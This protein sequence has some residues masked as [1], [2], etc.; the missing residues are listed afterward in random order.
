MAT[1]TSTAMNQH[2]RA[3]PAMYVGLA[4]TVAT[5]IA[6]YVDRA[7][8][9]VLASHIAA[10][11]PAYSQ[12]RLDSAVTIWLVVFSVVGA[13]GVAGW[14]GTIWAVESGKGW[15]RWTA[16]TLFALGISIA[17]T[18]VLITEPTGQQGLPL[19]LAWIGVLPSLAGAVA[20]AKLWRSS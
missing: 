9:G 12:A 5:T 17:L 7:T 15:A 8:T 18:L 3:V 14:I 20:V 6:P 11:W 4:L 2:R 16:T 19:V 13:L 10:G 1:M